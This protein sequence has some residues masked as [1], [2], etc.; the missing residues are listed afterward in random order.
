MLAFIGALLVV[1]SAAPPPP[2]HFFVGRME[3]VGTVDM[4]L[5]RPHRV[6]VRTQGRMA[7][8]G[9][10][11]MDQVVEEEGKPP[12]SRSWRLVRSGPNR[13]TGTVTDGRGPVTGEMEGNVLR[14]R[15]RTNQNISVDQTITLHRGGRTA[16]NRMTFRRFGLTVATYEETIRRVD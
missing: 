16:H 11:I 14:L 7:R 3:S 2:E 1:Q 13:F 9:A 6:R 12:R 8:D 4:I 10:L 5:S 15:Y